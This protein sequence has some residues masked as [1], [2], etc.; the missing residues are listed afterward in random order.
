M[1]YKSFN[2]KM[3]I[4]KC[5]GR[6]MQLKLVFLFIMLSS[7][8]YSQVEKDTL[9]VLFVGNSY[10][11][12]ENLTQIV[13]IISDSTKTK[14]ITKKSTVGGVSLRQHWLGLKGLKTKEKIK[15]G[16]FDIVVI[17]G[18]SMSTIKMPDSIS[19]YAKL[20]CDYIKTNN[21]KPYLYQ[22]WAREK[23][24]QF[25]EAITRVYEDI[26]INNNVSLVPVGE[27]WKLAK[28]LRPEI[29][30]FSPDGS[31]PSRQGTFLTACVFIGS[32]LREIP[33]NLPSRIYTKDI[34][35]ELLFLARMDPL[36]VAFF[37]RIAKEF[38]P[39]NE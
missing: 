38:I 19:K 1:K 34:D 15:K 28:Q 22:T 17:Q 13:S 26:S 32:I 12:F 21:A 4:L 16:N 7:T 30:L 3:N 29:K 39:K 18:H 24:P 11:Y 9:K 20:F 37:K 35:G 33:E 27:A 8:S 6:I 2:K 23:V 25:Q 31:H 10:T 14:L 36:D 5:M